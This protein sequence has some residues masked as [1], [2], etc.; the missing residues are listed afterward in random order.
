MTLTVND[1][2]D[3]GDCYLVSDDSTVFALTTDVTVECDGWDD[4]PLY[5]V[6]ELYDGQTTIAIQSQSEDKS[7]TFILG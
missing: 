6:F 1:V 3:S 7:A 5:Y 4:E 2:L